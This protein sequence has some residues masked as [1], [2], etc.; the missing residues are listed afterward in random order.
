MDGMKKRKMY[1]N[2]ISLDVTELLLLV[3]VMDMFDC[4]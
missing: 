2:M 3:N 1:T 4:C